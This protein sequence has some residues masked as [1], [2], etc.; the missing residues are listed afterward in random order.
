[1]S[2]LKK[3]FIIGCALA[4]LVLGVTRLISM[5][6]YSHGRDVVVDAL[7]F[8]GAIIAMIVYPEG[9]HTGQGSPTWGTF[10][11]IANLAAYIIFWYCILTVIRRPRS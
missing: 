4:F 11:A 1:M 7:S 10:A 8:P 6:P 3:R 2:A 9:V 5:L